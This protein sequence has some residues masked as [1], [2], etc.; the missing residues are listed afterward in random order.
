MKGFDY[1]SESS[2]VPV[3]GTLL[4]VSHDLVLLMK[5]RKSKSLFDDAEE[6]SMCL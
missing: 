4:T 3:N 1:L 2:L 5:T 6:D